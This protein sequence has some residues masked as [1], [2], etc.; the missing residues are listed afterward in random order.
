MENGIFSPGDSVRVSLASEQG[1]AILRQIQTFT[2]G[3]LFG[4]LGRGC[5]RELFSKAFLSIFAR[6]FKG[7][8]SFLF[9]AF[10]GGPILFSRFFKG[11]LSF[12]LKVVLRFLFRIRKLSILSGGF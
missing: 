6:L 5:P 8:L 12:C 1:K 2:A 11:F 4:F 3:M 9:K 10:S 7:V